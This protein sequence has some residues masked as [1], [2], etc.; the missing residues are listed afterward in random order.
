MTS[1]FPPSNSGE[2]GPKWNGDAK[3]DSVPIW[4]SGVLNSNTIGL[5]DWWGVRAGE[6][7]WVSIDKISVV[8][9]APVPNKYSRYEWEM[10]LDGILQGKARDVEVKGYDD[11]ALYKRNFSVNGGE[12]YVSFARGGDKEKDSVR[13]EFNPA[14]GFSNIFSLLRALPL[15]E[16]GTG[17]ITRLDFAVDY[18]KHLDPLAFYDKNKRKYGLFGGEDGPETLYLGSPNSEVRFRVYNKAKEL[19]E[20]NG[21]KV[22]FPVWRVEAEVRGEEN[23]KTNPFRNLVSVGCVCSGSDWISVLMRYYARGEGVQALLSLMPRN[24]RKRRRKELEENADLS[25]KPC[26]VYEKLFNG[27]WRSLA[28]HLLNGYKE[29]RIEVE[30]MVLDD[31]AVTV[32]ACV[33]L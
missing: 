26:E 2:K 19:Y 1:P 3:S 14:K 5:G 16:F 30:P 6:G 29:L 28:S 21:F 27:M 12:F 33:D 9:P 7:V 22:D 11:K 10:I 15:H 32:S 24:T 8:Y 23:L 17:K 13:F 31:Q 25:P 4:Y 20:A 18:L